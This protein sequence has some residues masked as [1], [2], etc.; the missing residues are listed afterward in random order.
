MLS[1]KKEILNIIVDENG[2]SKWTK[3][4]KNLS[5]QLINNLFGNLDSDKIDFAYNWLLKQTQPNSKVYSLLESKLFEK[6]LPFLSAPFAINNNTNTNNNIDSISTSMATNINSS[7]SNS[8]SSKIEDDIIV[9][10]E[11]RNVTDRLNQLI[12]FNYNVFSD[13]YTSYLN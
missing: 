13:M 3:N 2:N 11:L 5:V 10:D 1:F 12:E 8:T 7:N 9:N 4:L 6:I